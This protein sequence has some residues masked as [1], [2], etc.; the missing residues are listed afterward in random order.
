MGKV[1]GSLARAGKVKS[2][3]PKVRSIYGS[4]EHIPARYATRD[5]KDI[6]R[7]GTVAIYPSAIPP[8]KERK[9]LIVDFAI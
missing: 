7:H 2:Q 1:H 9:K 3:T 6:F 4:S 5:R 8:L